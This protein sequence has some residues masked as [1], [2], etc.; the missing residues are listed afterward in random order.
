LKESK[1][2]NLK[3]SIKIESSSNLILRFVS[4]N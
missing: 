3:F 4:M 1:Y 2:G